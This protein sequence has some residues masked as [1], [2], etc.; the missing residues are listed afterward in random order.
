MHT[1][2]MRAV[3]IDS[4]GG[5]EGLKVEMVKRPHAQSDRVRVRVHAAALNRADILQRRGRY[6][7]PKGSPED[8]PGLEFAGEVDQT[9]EEVQ[10]WRVGERVFGIT[11]GGG[12]AEYV[13]VPENHLSRI[14]DNLNWEEAAAVPEVFITAHDALFTRMGLRMGEKV[15]V[16]AAGSGVGTAAIQL[17]KAAGAVCYGTARSEEKLLRCEELGLHFGILVGSDIS[18]LIEHEALKA[19]V[20]L[21]LD[22]V[23]GS[24]LSTNL[25]LLRPKGRLMF[26][27][28]LS[29]SKSELDFGIVIRKR[30]TL[31]GTALRSR[32]SEE[33]ALATNEFARHVIPLLESGTVRP[34]IDSL[35]PVEEVRS[36]HERLESNQTFGKVILKF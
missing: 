13:V 5:T 14:P 32:S 25:N 34:V 20:D 26:V 36:A 16:H 11:G 35:F 10:R 17:A 7:A 9:G 28:T 12:Q 15:L 29:G 18:Q 8:I 30:L 31:M 1:E 33:K 19:G 21:I 27:G 23:G 6:P 24:Y 2:K 22:L 3:R 4:F